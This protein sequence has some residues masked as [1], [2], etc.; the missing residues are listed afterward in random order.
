MWQYTNCNELYH[1]GVPGMK[2]GVRKDR[3]SISSKMKANFY[4]YGKKGGTLPKGATLR[5]VALSKEDKTYDNKKYVSHNPIDDR[6]WQAYLGAGYK[7]SGKKTYK[8]KYTTLSDIKVASRTEAGDVFCKT[9]IDKKGNLKSTAISDSVDSYRKLVGYVPKHM[10]SYHMASVNMA[11]QT[12]TGKRYIKALL[13]SGY[14]AVGDYHGQNISKDPLII[15]NPDKKL[16]LTS[17]KRLK[18]L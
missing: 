12:K 15:L 13:D 11:M 1:H 17:S 3:L 16:K 10:K 2:W 5:R 6:R 18:V 7:K 4:N 14:D 8:V 9:F